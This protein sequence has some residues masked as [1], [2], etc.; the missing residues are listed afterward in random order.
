MSRM[1]I[2]V[3]PRDLN[4]AESAFNRL[5]WETIER[6]GDGVAEYGIVFRLPVDDVRLE[7]V[8]HDEARVTA[9]AAGSDTVAGL[10]I[11]VSDAQAAFEAAR[12]AGLTLDASSAEGPTDAPFGRLVRT[13]A[14]GGL[15][16][17]FVQT[18][19]LFGVPDN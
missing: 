9:Q 12:L 18:Q 2:V 17:D 10:R 16:I 5:G 4:G 3:Y 11:G 14:P 6:F 13:Y 8:V 15:R 7:I 19:T 1:D